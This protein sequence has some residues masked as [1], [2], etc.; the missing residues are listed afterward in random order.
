MDND[1]NFKWV[2]LTG[3]TFGQHTILGPPK[4]KINVNNIKTIE[5]IKLILKHLDMSFTAD[6]VEEF[7]EMKH[8]LILN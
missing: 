6:N 1:D 7:E 3:T 5:D 2:D 4:Y 8:L